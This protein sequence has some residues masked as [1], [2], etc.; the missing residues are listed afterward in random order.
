MLSVCV[1]ARVWTHAHA[2]FLGVCFTCSSTSSALF[3]ALLSGLANF[4]LEFFDNMGR[5]EEVVACES[6]QNENESESESVNVW[7]GAYVLENDRMSE[8]AN[9]NE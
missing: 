2:N 6:N 7:T 9:K 1:Y 3:L 8:R 4:T 5:D